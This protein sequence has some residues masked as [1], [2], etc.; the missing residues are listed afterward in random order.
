MKYV[1]LAM[2]AHLNNAC[3]YTTLNLLFKSQEDKKVCYIQYFRIYPSSYN[4]ELRDAKTSTILLC[5]F[6]PISTFCVNVRDFTHF[7]GYTK[8]NTKIDAMKTTCL[9]EMFASYS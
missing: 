9:E 2:D 3:S 8:L 7:P 5:I 4:R 6:S 1:Y